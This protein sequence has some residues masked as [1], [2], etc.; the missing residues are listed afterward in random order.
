VWAFPVWNAPPAEVPSGFRS[1]EG[2]AAWFFSLRS[3]LDL[4]NLELMDLKG[5]RVIVRQGPNGVPFFLDTQPRY[6]GWPKRET[7]L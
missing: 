1:S 6:S 7:F 3:W 4:R 2:N 5:E